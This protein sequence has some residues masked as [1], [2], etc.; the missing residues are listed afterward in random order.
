MTEA[1]GLQSGIAAAVVTALALWL[2]HPV[3]LRWQLVDVPRGR[4]R[5]ETPTPFI[6]GVAILTGV[7]A[8]GATSIGSSE[9]AGF[10]LGCALLAGVGLLDDKYDVKWYWRVLVQVLATL[11][12]VV[13]D[14]VKV[15]HFG[16]VFGLSASGLGVMSVPFTVIA[17][18]G[19]INAVNMVDGIDGAAGSLV[20]AALLLLAGAAWYSGNVAVEHHAVLLLGAVVAFLAHNMR[21]P[22]Q[23]RARCFLGN[24]GS[25]FLGFAMAWLV[26]RLTQNQHHPVS[27]VLALWF[28]PIPVMDTLVLMVRRIRTRRSP[29]A[30]DRNHIHHL[31]EDAGLGPTRASLL[32]AGVTLACGLAAG[33][34][35]RADVPE[36]LLLG[37]F[38]LLC[39]GWYGLSRRRTR[40]VGCLR[41]LLGGARR[42][43]RPARPEPVFPPP[44]PM[45]YT[46]EIAVLRA[47]GRACRAPARADDLLGQMLRQSDRDIAPAQVVEHPFG[48]PVARPPGDDERSRVGFCK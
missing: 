40:A 19:L 37:A 39:L 18:V 31:I 25:M 45:G 41:L 20:S 5:H 12:M 21:F 2:L 26:F 29:F 17:T 13:L 4:K 32:L 8:V 10:A 22:W 43:K 47:T 27:P 38:G 15:E 46:A 7:L 11:S 42:P 24:T 28:L 3:A 23:P 48:R 44:R 1:F 35:L 9:H 30:A 14:G 6:G 34:A 16:P 33:Q 36:P